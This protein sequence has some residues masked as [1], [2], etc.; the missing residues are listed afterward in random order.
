MND[1]Q[2]LIECLLKQI[3][4]L[5]STYKRIYVKTTST[6]QDL[7]LNISMASKAITEVQLS[8][9]GEST[10]LL[11]DLF[12]GDEFNDVFGEIKS[13]LKS[14]NSDL[15]AKWALVSHLIG[16]NAAC[17]CCLDV[18]TK[19]L[20][21]ALSYHNFLQNSARFVCDLMSQQSQP[22]EIIEDITMIFID[23]NGDLNS[24]PFMSDAVIR[25]RS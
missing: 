9:F 25:Y 12:D 11:I 18:T 2:A 23:L 1:S 17:C 8:Q 6:I 20:A 16:D 4:Q 19:W 10:N 21:P 3:R 24:L 14:L 13:S 15:K 5:K 7:A 22:P